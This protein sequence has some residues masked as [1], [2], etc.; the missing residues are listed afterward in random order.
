LVPSA[1]NIDAYSM[2]ITPAPTTTM[3]GGTWSR[4]RIWSESTTVRPSKSTVVGRAG[5]VPTAT[6]NL[7]AVTRRSVPSSAVTTTAF[8]SAKRAV[9]MIICTWLRASWL[10]ITSISRPITCWVRAVRSP[11]VISSFNR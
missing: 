6:T 3:V 10:R 9:P 8:G 11:T 7:S 2:P 4:S 5:L 1:A